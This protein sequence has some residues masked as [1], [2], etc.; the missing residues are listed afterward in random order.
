MHRRSLLAA[1]AALAAAPALAQPSAPW[2]A[3][4]ARM[5]IPWPPGQ[6]TDLQGRLVSQMLTKRLG[7]NVVPENR[8]GAGGQI[9]TD[10]VAKS[11]PDG[12][13][14]L[15]AS[16]GPIT[17]SP[18][19]QRTPYVVERD[20]AP[21]AAYGLSPYMLLVRPDF[22]AQTARDFVRLL[23]AS[24]GK[25]SYAS[26]GIGGAQHLL[27]AV[28]NAQAGID[29][30]H[31]PFQGSGPAMAAFLGGQV[32]YAIETIAAAGP[33][34]KQGSLRPLGITTKKASALLPGIPPLAEAADLPD[35]DIGGW[36]G[37]M[38]PAGTPQPIL[39]RLLAEVMA[40]FATE[41]MKERFVGIGVELAP[42]GPDGFR[43]LLRAE[44]AL[45]GPVIKQ[46][47]IRAE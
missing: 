5:I 38:L 35:Y 23:K 14:M 41:E 32:D 45:F 33:L 16:I 26:S 42:I 12:Y 43:S 21:V 39:D 18:L 28:F 13:T 20:F 47:G 34:V 15:A 25:Y 30:L 27:T 1:G 37:L 46:L 7:Q 22:P 40:G 9:G 6:S 4:T 8:G 10:Y 3:R 36:N 19:V 44:A 2:P 31:V 11:P 29:A 17:F 24:P